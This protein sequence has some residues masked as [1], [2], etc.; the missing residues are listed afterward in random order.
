MP[1]TSHYMMGVIYKYI[2]GQVYRSVY[3][4]ALRGFAPAYEGKEYKVSGKNGMG[5]G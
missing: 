3:L 2:Q 1:G 4:D 5:D